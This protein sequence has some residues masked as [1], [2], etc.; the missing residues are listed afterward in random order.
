MLNYCSSY[1]FSSIVQAWLHGFNGIH[2]IRPTILDW[3]LSVVL[4]ACRTKSKDRIRIGRVFR[5]TVIPPDGSG[6]R[7]SPQRACAGNATISTKIIGSVKTVV[8]IEVKSFIYLVWVWRSSPP[9]YS[10]CTCRADPALPVQVFFQP[11][12]SLAWLDHM[13]LIK[14]VL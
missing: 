4:Y 5:N 7:P 3:N 11:L 12:S 14:F 10:G 8:A 9:I 1:T 6:F 2:S 13:K